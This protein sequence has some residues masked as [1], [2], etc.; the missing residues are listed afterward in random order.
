MKN[1][2]KMGVAGALALS[3][4]MAAHATIVGPTSSPGSTGDLVL[5]A[6]VFTSTGTLVKAYA[7][8]TGVSV[9]SIGS[10]TQPSG[11]FHDANLD[12]LLALA[13][14]GTTTIWVLEGG[15]R[16]VNAPYLISSSPSLTPIGAQNGSKLAAWGAG[17]VNQVSVVN[18][19]LVNPTD[20]SLLTTDNSS[21]GTG[22][23]PFALA[24]DVTN[25]YGQTT[26]V[27]TT[28]LGTQTNIYR[29]T[30]SGISSANL[31]TITGIFKATLTSAGL[32]FQPFSAV[33]LPA[34]VWLLGSGLLG[35]AGVARRKV[36]AA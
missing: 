16:H 9:D 2:V 30:A 11:T 14:A 19:V 34:A 22:F 8:D 26:S 18:G 27:A 12:S 35:L 31:A 13:T 3:G 20:T 28:G 29:A 15:Y 24:S 7:G 10:G 1:L 4:S 25:W 6:D 32:S 5:F 33:P 17:L 23:N 21:F 36:G